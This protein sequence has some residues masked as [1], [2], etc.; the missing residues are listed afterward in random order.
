MSEIYQLPDGGN[1]VPAWLPA[2]NNNG[3]GGNGWGGGILGFLL[4]LVFGNGGFGGFGNYGGGTNAQ[5]QNFLMEAINHN[6]ERST[7]AVQ[8]LSST[9]NQDFN[10]VNSAVQSI[11]G[12]LATLSAQHGLTGQQIINSIQA[13]N[14]ALG[15]QLQQSCC[16]NQLA[17]SNLSNTVATTGNA[18]TQ[19]ILAKLGEMQTQALQDKLD[20]SRAENTRLAGELSQTNQ[21]ATIAAMMANTVNPIAAQLAGIRAEVDAIKRCQPQT[22]TLPNNSMTA[23][24]TIWANAVADN[25]VDKISSA[26]N[27]TTSG[28]TTTVQG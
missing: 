17:I 25:V 3:L 16:Q 4:G 24:P 10:L 12:A 13:G 15:A 6:G 21:N 28:T 5:A 11:S 22:I 9:I 7:A 1:S 23:V 27:P 26:L 2:M 19:A 20:A 18:N 8:A 14:A